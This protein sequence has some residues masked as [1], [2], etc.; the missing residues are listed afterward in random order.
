MLYLPGQV[1][2]SGVEGRVPPFFFGSLSRGGGRPGDGL[3]RQDQGQGRLGAKTSCL[4]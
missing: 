3:G 1:I 4:V 2:L